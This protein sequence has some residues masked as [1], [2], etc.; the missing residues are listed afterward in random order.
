MVEPR[1]LSA[2]HCSHAPFPGRGRCACCAFIPHAHT[3]SR[4]RPRPAPR[5]QAPYRDQAGPVCL[6][7]GLPLAFMIWAKEP[8]SDSAMVVWLVQSHQAVF[9]VK[10]FILSCHHIP[11]YSAVSALST[12]PSAPQPVNLSPSSP[13]RTH[14]PQPFSQRG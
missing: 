10:S 7:G 13:A 9:L 5:C 2:N 12:S 14:L 8:K 3:P 1:P 6:P 4:S 11:P